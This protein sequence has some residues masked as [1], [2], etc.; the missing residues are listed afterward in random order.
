[1]RIR[2]IGQ[3]NQTGI[4]IHYARFT[5]ELKLVQG[6]GE[7]VDEVNF[8]DNDQVEQA[9]QTSQSDDINISFVSANI[10][11]HF[12]GKIIQ[13]IV[14]ESTKI[15]DHILEALVKA[16]QVWVPSSW[17]HSILVA[18]GIRS[19]KIRIV[20]EGVDVYRFHN[21]G[22][23]Q[24]KKDR[25]FRFLTVGKYEERKSLNETI[26]AFAQM[27]AN[28]DAIELI[29]KSNYFVNH[30]E[31]LQQ[32]QKKINDLKLT[33]V[34]VVWGDMTDAEVANLYRSC[35]IFILP[36]KAEG[37]GLP[38]IEAA[39]SGMPIITTPYSGQMEFLNHIRSSVLDV[40]YVLT[41]VNCPEFQKYYPDPD[42]DWG[43]W[44]RPD[45]FSISQA[46]QSACRDY[47]SGLYENAQK[48]SK[49]IRN[50]YSWQK[51]VEKAL[52][53]MGF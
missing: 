29:I 11:E 1:M 28:T 27:Y 19:N 25:V 44:A 35:D 17:G 14:F 39:A 34:H 12:K 42:N 38:L 8:Q 3:R 30:D 23:K 24:Y 10:H 48:N 53:V 40:D 22:R 6:I 15:A 18:N 36:T 33:N 7:L 43:K 41:E 13:W 47:W 21:F 31:K 16:D 50:S 46:M 45:V 49:I 5:D 4:G 37:W 26:E 2:L 20:P 9:I 51:S 32:L 52:V